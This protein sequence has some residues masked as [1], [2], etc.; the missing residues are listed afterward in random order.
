MKIFTIE[1]VTYLTGELKVSGLLVNVVDELFSAGMVDQGLT[2]LRESKVPDDVLNTVHEFV[3][4]LV[5]KQV[6]QASPFAATKPVAV[7]GPVANASI[8]TIEKLLS[9]QNKPGKVAARYHKDPS[10]WPTVDAFGRPFPSL[11]TI[12]GLTKQDARTLLT[13]SGFPKC[14][15]DSL[16]YYV[17]EQEGCDAH[18]LMRLQLDAMKAG[19]VFDASTAPVTIKAGEWR[20]YNGKMGTEARYAKPEQHEATC[21]AQLVAPVQYLALKAASKPAVTAP[22]PTPVAV[23]KP[24][25]VRKAPAKFP[26][27]AK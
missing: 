23:A 3:S 25:R 22:I 16:M 12:A 1:Q 14:S 15:L 26:G 4:S 6:P 20:W 27:Q 24:Q 19:Q 13:G 18:T 8:A 11:A 21:A 5:P 9:Y 10:L 17:Q 7:A 2:V